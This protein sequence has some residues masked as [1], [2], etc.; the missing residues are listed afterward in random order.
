MK[1]KKLILSSLICM[2]LIATPLVSISCMG[3]EIKQTNNPENIKT[4]KQKA[5]ELFS[6]ESG[7]NYNNA[8]M[9]FSLGDKETQDFAKENNLKDI[10][11]YDLLKKYVTIKDIDN[12]ARNYAYRWYFVDEG[13][14]KQAKFVLCSIPL[15]AIAAQQKDLMDALEKV[16]NNWMALTNNGKKIKTFKLDIKFDID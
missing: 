12:Y 7:N 6:V 13:K 2:P 10:D 1:I 11:N 5:L 4:S 15:K 9:K 8:V 16:N 14:P 3:F